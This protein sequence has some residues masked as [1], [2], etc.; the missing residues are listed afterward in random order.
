LAIW[1]DFNKAFSVSGDGEH[2]A[3]KSG[4]RSTLLISRILPGVGKAAD[5]LGADGDRDLP[6]EGSEEQNIGKSYVL[7]IN[8]PFSP[9]TLTL[10]VMYPLYPFSIFITILW[11]SRWTRIAAR[12][13][14][15]PLLVSRRSCECEFASFMRTQNAPRATTCVRYVTS[16]A[17]FT[18]E[19]VRRNSDNLVRRRRR[20]RMGFDV[21]FRFGHM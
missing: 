10:D 8:R 2:S 17:G 19:L 3:L 4:T 16:K 21:E 15:M 11:I 12:P 20:T 13:R 18:S 5:I 7:G 9:L 1:L 6:Y 14:P